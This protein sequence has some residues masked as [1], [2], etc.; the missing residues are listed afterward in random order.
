MGLTSI[1]LIV[2]TIISVTLNIIVLFLIL[3][4]KEQASNRVTWILLGAYGSL[5]VWILTSYIQLDLITIDNDPF[6]FSV[7]AALGNVANFAVLFLLM[8]F[9]RL[10]IEPRPNWLRNSYLLSLSTLLLGFALVAIYGG[11]ENNR[12]LIETCWTFANFVNLIIVPSVVVFITKDTR[13][14]L[15]EPMSEKQ[16]KQVK[17]LRNGLLFGVI[18]VIP[19]VALQHIDHIFLSPMLLVASVA[20]FFLIQGYLIDPRV[21]FMVPHRAYLLIVADDNGV[22]KYSKNFID[23]TA[24]N[25]DTILITAGLTAISSMMSEFYKTEVHSL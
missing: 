21:A 13:M 2:M 15:S 24:A 10:L 12:D 19:F 17:K 14:L 8:N 18:G 4:Q 23:Q 20:L 22:L 16:R 3:R 5:L 7:I 6:G 9:F 25:D 11:S 1:L